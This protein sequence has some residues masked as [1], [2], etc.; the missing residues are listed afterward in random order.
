[1][2]KET[3]GTP[4]G[5]TLPSKEEIDRRKKE[6]KDT[7][8]CPYCGDRLKKWAVPQSVEN[9]WPNEFMY[10]CL[11][12]E[13]PYFLRGWSV[14]ESLG[15]KCSYRLMYDPLTDSCQPLPVPNSR[16]LKDCIIDEE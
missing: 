15:N 5:R 12:D 8:C 2:Q 4:Q 6:V 10:V 13:C 11:N 7:L 1:M 9:T 16:V 3:P 14:M